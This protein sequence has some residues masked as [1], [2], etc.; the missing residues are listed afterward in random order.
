MSNLLDLSLDQGSDFTRTLT[1]SRNATPVDLTTGHSFAAMAR[2]NYADT[3][4]AF[5]FA[6][7]IMDQT[8]NPGKVIMSLAHASAAAISL[9]DDTSRKFFYDVEWTDE[10]DIVKKILKGKVTVSAEATK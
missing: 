8:L 10:N 1:I 7:E 4:P 9:G 3:L 2:V 6:F 5:T